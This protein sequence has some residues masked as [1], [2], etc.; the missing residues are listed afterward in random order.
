MQY[1]SGEHVDS[2]ARAKPMAAVYPGVTHQEVILDV[3]VDAG[4]FYGCDPARFAVAQ[5]CSKQVRPCMSMQFETSKITPYLKRTRVHSLVYSRKEGRALTARLPCSRVTAQCTAPASASAI[6]LNAFELDIHSVTINGQPVVHSLLPYQW[7]ALPSTVLEATGS[8]VEAAH[9]S[10]ADDA[11]TEYLRFLRQEE[12]PELICQVCGACV[13]FSIH[14]M[15]VHW[16]LDMQLE[17][18]APGLQFAQ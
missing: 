18:G 7:E 8:K 12:S 9:A 5:D 10:V 3:R 4:K 16:H 17:L 2:T 6:G 11:A 13:R 15:L 14:L 1:N